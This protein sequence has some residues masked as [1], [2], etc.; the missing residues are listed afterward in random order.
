M[1]LKNEGFEPTSVPEEGDHPLEINYLA[2]LF[3]ERRASE[4]AWQ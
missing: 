1:K 3:Q 4:K 2:F